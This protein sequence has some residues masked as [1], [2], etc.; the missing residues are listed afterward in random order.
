M[1]HPFVYLNHGALD[2]DSFDKAESVWIAFERPVPAADRA[3]IM[4]TCPMAFAGFF[5]WD[6]ALF[7]SESWGDVYGAVVASDYGEG[8][9][10][11]SAE[12]AQAFSRDVEAWILGIHARNPVAFFIGPSRSLDE[13]GWNAWS[14]ARV[15]GVIVPWLER[16]LDAHPDLPEAVEDVVGDDGEDEA[17]GAPVATPMDRETLAYIAQHL[18]GREPTREE[19]ARAHAL[20]VRL[21]W[22]PGGEQDEDGER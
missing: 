22:E 2:P 1:N 11:V 14:Y 15:G 9:M 17:G 18:E 10:E 13:E 8:G 16:Y 21:G 7:Y 5:R 20:S 3:A 19:Q 6:D 12:A 4:E